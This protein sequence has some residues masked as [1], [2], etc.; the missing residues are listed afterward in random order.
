MSPSR[1]S[2]LLGAA[3]APVLASAAPAAEAQSPTRP[4][5]AFRLGVN[6]VP[7]RNWWF[8]WADWDR[9]SIARDLDRIAALGMDH[10]RVMCVWPELQPNPH[11]VRGE[12]LD[13]VAELLDLADRVRLDVEVTVF[14]GAV[15]GL[16]FIPPWLIDNGTG[17]VRD[18]FTDP[19][20]LAAQH[21]MLEALAARIG[22]H[23]RFLGFDLSNEVHWAGIPLGLKP[24]PA[25]G[26]A[27]HDTLFAT[28]ER[29]AP[30]KLHVSGIDHYPW[31]NDAYF[32]RPGLGRSGTA[33]AVHTW[34]G[35][36]RV[37]QDFGPLSTPSVHYSEYF[38]EVIKAFHQDLRRQAWV[39]ETG[40][41]TKWMAAELIPEW[42]ERS[43]RA[44]ASCGDVWGVSWWCS[45]DLNPKLSGFNPLEYDLGLLTNAGA[46]KPIGDVLARLAHEYD[47]RPPSP[48][49]RPVALVLPTEAIPG[50]DFLKAFARLVDAGTRPAVVRAE[51]SADAAYL[52][53]RHIERL[54]HPAEV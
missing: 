19:D 40:V 26:D 44:M 4:R 48:L 22:G 41:S 32:S 15:S 28:C 6:Y 45:H 39:E 20:A 2:F 36:T 17:K 30:G 27:W 47:H 3:A 33:S 49:P 18:W 14:N 16:L 43:I 42:T 31:L 34:A 12:Q 13:R 46:R 50:L 29:V 51:R 1:R 38:I 25:Q 35:W 52:A 53:A 7:S 11:Y 37:I 9:A 54:V 8:S 24:T 21:R 10:I 5:R 23:R